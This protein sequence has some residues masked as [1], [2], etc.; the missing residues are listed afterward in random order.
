MF[1]ISVGS[2]LSL[3]F[4]MPPAHLHCRVVWRRQVLCLSLRLR[5]GNSSSNKSIREWFIWSIV[6]YVTYQKSA[7]MKYMTLCVQNLLR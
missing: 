2:V 6:E 5:I 4:V 1:Q 7:D 3:A